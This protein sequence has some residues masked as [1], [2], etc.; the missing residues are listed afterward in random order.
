MTNRVQREFERAANRLAEIWS[1]VVAVVAFVLI[2]PLSLWFA[3]SR[4]PNGVEVMYSVAETISCVSWGF[5]FVS[6]LQ[7]NRSLRRLGLSGTDAKSLFSGSRPANSDELTAWKWG[8]RFMYGI[9]AVL[10]CMMALPAISWF[11]G[12]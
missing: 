1:Y 9:I 10:V 5:T 12:K 4:H 11:T 6:M 8:W 3:W 2:I 7:L